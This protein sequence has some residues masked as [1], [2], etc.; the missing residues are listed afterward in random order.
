MHLQNVSEDENTLC[1]GL[2]VF[3]YYSAARY[4]VYHY[5]GVVRVSS[6]SIISPT[7]KSG[8]SQLVKSLFIVRKFYRRYRIVRRVNINRYAVAAVVL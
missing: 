1:L 5:S 4:S 3:V 6:F 2:T 8:V 7:D